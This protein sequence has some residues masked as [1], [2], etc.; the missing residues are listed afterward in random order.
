MPRTYQKGNNK[1]PYQNYSEEQLLAAIEDVNAGIGIREAARRHDINYTT[2]LYKLKQPI[3]TAKK[4]GRPTVLSK[5]EERVIVD[6]IQQVTAWGFGFCRETVRLIIKDYLDKQN[7]REPRFSG[8]LPGPDF[9]HSFMKR[10]NLTYRKP[11]NIK[12]AR[13][14]VGARTINKF[15]DNLED[16]GLRDASPGS[17]FNYD[18]TAVADDPGAKDVIVPRG[19]KRVE[20][21]MEHS[22][23]SISIMACGSASGVFL[24]PYVVYKAENVYEGWTQGGPAGIMYNCSKTGWF[25]MDIFT[26]WFR[27][28]F[29]EHVKNIPGTKYLLGDNL[30]SHFSVEVVRLAQIHDIIFVALPPN[31]TNLLQPLDVSVFKPFK[32]AWSVVLHNFRKESRSKGV[33]PKTVFPILLRQ[34][35]QEV[36]RNVGVNLQSG[37]RA[38]GLHPFNRNEVLKRVPDSDINAGSGDADAIEV[39]RV[40]DATLIS[41]LKENRGITSEATAST[42]RG[43]GRGRGKKIEP[44]RPILPSDLA[45]PSSSSSVREPAHQDQDSGE[46]AN[47]FCNYARYSGPDW[48]RCT[49]CNQWYCGVCN[50]ASDDPYY[51]CDLC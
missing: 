1:R 41:M 18:E 35:Y 30:A 36:S 19:T 17:V 34:L 11:G 38:T 39:G 15:F 26:D 48:I 21:V 3:G 25:D 6:T 4:P 2:L 50:G 51:M 16:V 20:V 8:N 37:F 40:I 5:V 46:C 22:K 33:I 28:I 27:N 10:N 32:N 44:G 29:L 7:R 12:R 23:T 13:A 43:R 24:P 49:Q 14:S 31:S 45:G 9:V 42:G 47:C